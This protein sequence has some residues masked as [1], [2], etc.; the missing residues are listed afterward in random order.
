MTSLAGP[1]PTP[2]E[3]MRSGISTSGLGT[4]MQLIALAMTSSL[5]SPILV[6]TTSLDGGLPL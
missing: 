2:L 1:I 3:Q 5:L 6:Q 4:N